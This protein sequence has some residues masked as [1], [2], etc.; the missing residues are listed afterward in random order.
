M[1]AASKRRQQQPVIAQHA[2]RESGSAHDSM[3]LDLAPNRT[4][5]VYVYGVAGMEMERS[6]IELR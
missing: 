5:F 1:H 4:R 6:T 3:I 2:V